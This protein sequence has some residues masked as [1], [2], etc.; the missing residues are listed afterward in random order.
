MMILVSQPPGSSVCGQCVIAM[1]SG[2]HLDDVVSHMGTGR[3]YPDR[4][5][6]V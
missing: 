2:A 1:L 5:S 6:V 4:K 3:T